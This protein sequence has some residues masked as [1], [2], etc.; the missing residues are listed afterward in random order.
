M[1]QT[2]L[3]FKFKILSLMNKGLVFLLY[4]FAEAFMLL[5]NVYYNVQ[6]VVFLFL[7]DCYEWSVALIWMWVSLSDSQPHSTTWSLCRHT[8]AV[9]KIMAV[10]CVIILFVNNMRLSEIIVYW[11]EYIENMPHL[12]SLSYLKVHRGVQKHFDTNLGRYCSFMPHSNFDNSGTCCVNSTAEHNRYILS[13]FRWNV[14]NREAIREGKEVQK[15][16][17]HACEQDESCTLQ[18]MWHSINDLADD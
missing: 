18:L 12:S 2:D 5:Y 1:I 16:S 14:S 8:S 10:V 9:L 17:R 3:L 15:G 4:N 7:Y 13:F 6:C 11:G